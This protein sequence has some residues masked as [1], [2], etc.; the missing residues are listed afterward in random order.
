MA[1][2]IIV[3]DDSKFAR[4]QLIRVIPKKIAKN[5]YTAANGKEAMELLREGRGKLMFLDLN[6]PVMDGYEVL[7]AIRQEGLRVMIIVVSGDIQQQA[8]E[9]IKKYKV[10]SFLK[11]PLV[12]EE[13]HELLTKYGL[14]HEDDLEDLAD[15]SLAIDHSESKPFDELGEKINIA[16]GLAASKIADMLNLFVTMPLPNI[17]VET[18]TKIS[19]DIQSWLDMTG[20]IIVS[21]G[22]DGD[23]ILGESL[24]Y[25]S[26][27]DINTYTKAVT[28][29]SKL[30]EQTK[31]SLVME[32]ASIISGTLMRNF[33]HQINYIITFNFPG[34]VSPNVEHNLTHPELANSKIL[35][36]ELTYTIK[37]LNMNIKFQILF[38]HSTSEKLKEI[39]A[40]V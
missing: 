31:N 7:E 28:N 17:K 35:N 4:N 27:K 39:M 23:G 6:M 30:D 29:N 15:P 11:K 8:L 20:N 25:F 14:C 9:I 1:L 32:L 18:G 38:N 16:T 3:C 12:P 40:L 10:L 33:T 5:I 22:F 24:I 2:D 36:V 37:D 19:N 34:L 26:F 13:L 21:Q